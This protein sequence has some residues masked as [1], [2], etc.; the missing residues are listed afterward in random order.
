MRIAALDVD[1]TSAFGGS[2]PLDMTLTLYDGSGN[3]AAVAPGVAEALIA[4]AA[5]LLIA[6]FSLI[7][8]NYMNDQI[9]AATHELEDAGRQVELIL[10]PSS[11][12]VIPNADD[13]PSLPP[14]AGAEAGVHH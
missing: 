13:S 9:E 3:I 1:F 10:N 4:T 14:P 6:I 12:I 11:H 7:P 5:G 8:L 2:P